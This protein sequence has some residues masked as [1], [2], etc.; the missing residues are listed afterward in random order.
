[1]GLKEKVTEEMKSA[2]KSG[3]KVRLETVRSL[4]AMILEFEKSGIERE[5]TADDEAKMLNSAVKKRKESIE[6]FSAAGRTELVAK[7]EAELKILMEFM[8]KQLT[9]EEIEAEV[10]KTAAELNATGKEH[11]PLLMPAVMK[12]L[13]GKADGKLI[14]SLVEKTLGMN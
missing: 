1:M 12:V 4:R 9:E 3:D 13:K 2:M 7:E 11:F 8:P 6:Q 10:K 14:R 5:I